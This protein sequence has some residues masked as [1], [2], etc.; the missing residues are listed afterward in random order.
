MCRW[1]SG[2]TGERGEPGESKRNRVAPVPARPIRAN[3]TGPRGWNITLALRRA[4]LSPTLCGNAKNK[5]T[6]FKKTEK[7]K[8]KIY[9][10]ERNRPRP[11][12]LREARRGPIL[13]RRLYPAALSSVPLARR[14]SRKDTQFHRTRAS[15]ASNA[16]EDR[17]NRPDFAKDDGERK[18]NDEKRKKLIDAGSENVAKD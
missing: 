6:A 2:R 3:G 10:K 1:C 7:I 5:K 9:Q 8:I 14:F 16:K 4:A 15:P 18:I 12:S 11:P 13:P 17:K